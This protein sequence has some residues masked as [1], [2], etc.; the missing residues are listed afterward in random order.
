MIN[1]NTVR[2][3]TYHPCHTIRRQVVAIAAVLHCHPAGYLMVAAA[4]SFR[5]LLRPLSA[6]FLLEVAI[7]AGR[8]LHNDG[9]SHYLRRAGVVVGYHHH[10]GGDDTVCEC[11]TTGG[12]CGRAMVLWTL[13]DDILTGQS[14][15]NALRPHTDVPNVKN[16]RKTAENAS[17]NVRMP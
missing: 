2:S 10:I 7:V 17:L 4:L 14:N 9:G 5:Q 12:P 15:A 3:D 11:Y 13:R 16:D 1:S 6:P 8:R